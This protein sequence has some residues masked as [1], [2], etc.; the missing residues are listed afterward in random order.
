MEHLLESACQ[1][2]ELVVAVAITST[3]GT[4]L[5]Q[6]LF[7]KNRRKYGTGAGPTGKGKWKLYHTK[8]FPSSRCVWLVEGL[9]L[10]KQTTYNDNT[11]LVYKS[12]C[13]N[14]EEKNAI[15][16]ECFQ[17]CTC[18]YSCF[19]RLLCLPAD[20]MKTCDPF[21]HKDLYRSFLGS[22]VC[23]PFLVS[24]LFCICCLHIL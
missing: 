1:N 3:L 14:E 13:V 10:K 7:G 21:L 17:I 12:K 18:V 15:F 2:P 22:F 11:T 5:L 19:K 8:T 4:I 16:F 23:V 24:F 6:R 9:L 20:S